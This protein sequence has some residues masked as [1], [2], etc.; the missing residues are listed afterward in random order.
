M[1]SEA[2]IQQPSTTLLPL[3]L[4]VSAANTKPSIMGSS[5]GG[6]LSGGLTSA[7]PDGRNKIIAMKVPGTIKWV[8]VRNGYGFISRSNAKENVFV[9]Q[10]AIKKNNLRKYLCNVG[11]GETKEFDIVEGKKGVKAA[12]VT[13]PGGVPV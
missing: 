1:N 5:A 10:T 11:N 3:P 6:S 2:E 13:H 8:N 4:A 9:H 7:A 12:N